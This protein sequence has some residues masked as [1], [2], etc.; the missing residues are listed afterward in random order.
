M[1]GID[2]HAQEDSRQLSW[3]GT[4]PATA[5]IH[6][7]PPLDLSRETTG[8]LSLVIDYRVDSPPTAPVT[9]AMGASSVPIGG[10]LRAAPVGQWQT[11]TLPLG[12]F[13]KTSGD[14]MKALTTPLAITTAG[15]LQ[16]A[17]SGVRVLSATV[18]QDQ[19]GAP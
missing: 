17:I 11:L 15:Q 10:V 8:Q 13:A 4:G 16:L 6:A 19:C 7:N 3:T 14:A 18:P 12:C 2:R 5:A 1:K 9:L